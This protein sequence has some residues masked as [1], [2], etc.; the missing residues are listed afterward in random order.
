MF[1]GREVLQL[2]ISLYFN[3]THVPQICFL[4]RTFYLLSF[5]ISAKNYRLN[6]LSLGRDVIS[7]P[8]FVPLLMLE[9]DWWLL[10]N[11]IMHLYA[12]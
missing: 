12:T 2:D 8:F 4:M 6:Y 10:P 11:A 9:Y 3:R 5:N 7:G 1:I